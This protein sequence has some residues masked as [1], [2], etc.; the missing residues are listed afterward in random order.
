MDGHA[1]IGRYE[2]ASGEWT[3]FYY[4]LAEAQSP[5]GG[6]VGL[7]EIVATSDSDFLVVERDN[8]GG[9][10]ARIKKIFSFSIEG[11]TP[12]SEENTPNFPVVSKTEVRDLISDLLSDN[13]VVIEKVEGLTILANGDAL[14][15]TDND[16]VDDSSGETQLINLGSL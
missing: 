12:L 8:Q 9:L 7:S 6:W 16:G 10:D 15:V 2:V 14:I 5:N 11:L 1:R 13:G 4:P 3:F